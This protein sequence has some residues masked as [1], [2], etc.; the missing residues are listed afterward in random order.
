MT[1]IDPPL[2]VT[3]GKRGDAH[4]TV[5]AKI[6]SSIDRIKPTIA[7][8][9]SHTV[10]EV[11]EEDA[12]RLDVLAQE[13][14]SCHPEVIF[15]V[16]ANVGVFSRYARGLFPEAEIMAFEPV[17]ATFSMLVNNVAGENIQCNAIGLGTDSVMSLVCDPLSPMKSSLISP[18]VIPK[19]R[20]YPV[21]AFGKSLGNILLSATHKDTTQANARVANERAYQG[22]LKIDCEGGEW[23]LAALSGQQA[24]ELANI[25]A[26][27]VKWASI[28]IHRPPNLDTYISEFITK[29]ISRIFPLFDYSIEDVPADSDTC[30]CWLENRF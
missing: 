20:E 28:E 19:G 11:V 2:S 3:A 9:Y 15:D 25:V 4:R 22:F 13:H 10:Y 29:V 7:T 30:M 18:G 12:Y 14:P 5:L 21:N 17:P 6:R 16:G 24:Q 8:L 1:Y 26:P 23:C 27:R